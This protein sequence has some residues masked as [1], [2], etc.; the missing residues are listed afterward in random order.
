MSSNS[1]THTTSEGLELARDLVANLLCE[2]PTTLFENQ[3]IVSLLEV[4]DDDV[5]EALPGPVQEVTY[6][7]KLALQLASLPIDYAEQSP[8][9]EDY[10]R[11]VEDQRIQISLICKVALALVLGDRT[12]AKAADGNFKSPKGS[13]SNAQR[14]LQGSKQ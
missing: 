4:G 5:F 11:K 2:T 13:A 7:L 1:T 9:T 10:R 3:H 8:L 14:Q 6:H 12:N